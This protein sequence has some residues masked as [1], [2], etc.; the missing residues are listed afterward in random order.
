M[1]PTPSDSA[2]TE[3]LLEQAGKGDQQAFEALF[4][5]HRDFLCSVVEMRLDQRLRQRLDPS[6]V[7][8]EAYADAYRR[9]QDFLTRRPMSFRLWLRKTTQERLIKIHQQ[10]LEAQRRSVR[11]EIP[12]PDHSSLALAQQLI[13]GDLAPS[14]R[15]AQR[16]LATL[17]RQALAQLADTDREVLLMRYVEKWSN[18]EIGE[19]LNLD[20]DTVS[21]RHGRALLKLQQVLSELGIED[22][23]A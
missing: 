7:V 11:R 18:Q 6:D 9:L 22:S 4:S 12:L 20:P 14:Q 3:R 21:K 16:E 19:V 2:E 23:Q 10:H 17:V 15:A 1:N 5:K 8:Q 13:A